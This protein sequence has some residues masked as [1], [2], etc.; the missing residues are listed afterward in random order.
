MNPYAVN[1]AV[2]AG[3]GDPDAGGMLEVSRAEFHGTAFGMAPGIFVT[4]GHV[5]EA[6]AASRGKVALFRLTPDDVNGQ[7]V[8]EAQIFKNAD[9]ALLYSP[10]L[11]AE[12]LPFS[13]S[14]PLN[15][16]ENVAALGYAFGL[17]LAAPPNPHMYVMRG[18][19]GHIVTR[20]GL[21]ELPGVPPGYEVSFVPPPGL[22]GAPLLV[23][24]KD[25]PAIAG[26]IL[27]HHT[28]EL[29]GRRMDLGLAVD[30][31]ELLTLTSPIVGGSVAEQVFG[32]EPVPSRDGSP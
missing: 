31:E 15:Y 24:G 21:T 4:A 16:L 18:F 27:Q 6:A 9:L 13:F 25:G 12:I 30:A 20:R 28:A 29:A 7:F 19:K 17:T 1:L 2:V 23:F 5:Y 32:L 3:K 8:E 26:I 10:H 22:S 11:K 14:P